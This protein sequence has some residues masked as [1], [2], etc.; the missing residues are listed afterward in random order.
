M[1]FPRQTSFLGLAHTLRQVPPHIRVI[2]FDVFDT[3]IRRRVEPEMVKD[4]VARELVRVSGCGTDWRPLRQLRA[5][6]EQA[7][8]DERLATGRDGEFTLEEMMRRWLAG[9]AGILPTPLLPAVLPHLLAYE[10]KME[11]RA[12]ALTPHIRE[13]LVSLHRNDR[14]IVFVSDMYFPEEAI[15]G[16]LDNLGVG[17]CFAAGYTS[18]DH[19]RRKSTGRLFERVLEREDIAPHEL[20]FV[21]NNAQVDVEP[22]RRL[23]ISAIHIADADEHQRR[24]RLQ[25]IAW[26]G[27]R[28]SLWPG[29]LVREIIETIP[30]RARLD[31]PSPAYQLGLVMALPY[32]AFVLH[33][34]ETLQRLPIRE[35]YF[36]S[37]EG[38]LFFRLYRQL[39]R[40]LDATDLPRGRYLFAG[41]LPTF[42]P[43]MRRLEWAEVLRM[44]RQYNAQSMHVLLTN[45]SL[46]FEHFVPL[47]LRNGITEMEAP[48]VDPE[49]N[50]AFQRFLGDPE[51][52]S[53]FATHRDAAR[54]VLR[55]YLQQIGFFEGGT[56]HIA[57]VDVGWKG[58]I[59]DNLCRA[60][61]ADT[62]FPFVHGIY[63]GL[64][65]AT[66][67]P[68]RSTK[69][70]FLSDGRH[71]DHLSRQVFGSVTPFEM[72]ATAAH[73]SVVGYDQPPHRGG[74]V[75][76]RLRQHGIEVNYRDRVRETVHAI[77]DYLADFTHCLGL[78]EL[79][80]D[81]L[82][83]CVAD[84]LL[85]YVQ[86]PTRLEASV[87]DD[88]A[89]VESFGVLGLS[90]LRW[91]GLA[92][93]L[94]AGRPRQILAEFW[95]MLD[96]HLWP[97]L[98]LR[99]S[100][101]PFAQFAYDLRQTLRRVR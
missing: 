29:R 80:S 17:H 7:L 24:L 98:A 60:L 90:S 67:A 15:R 99:Q 79:R 55:C 70:A 84:Q 14:R 44:W 10:Y 41:R 101:L 20:L 69:T 94:R 59:Q 42:L 47:A 16:F 96:R 13:L 38:W 2:G 52:Q 11:C 62:R 21:G 48:I 25:V 22:A 46:P 66:T 82:R 43:S 73:G 12:Q 27:R 4:A 39:R 3:V 18:C 63:F 28:D 81:L 51:V 61:G 33:V 57:L 8:Y 35:V 86:Y 93:I 95:R 83:P 1:A 19:N 71:P 87:F 76:P 74:R 64:P 6:M 97:G 53:R 23:G 5:S 40:A 37:R 72:T 89:H 45:L 88:Y 75:V 91:D 68:P 58:S 100:R 78:F 77:D 56:G 36:L 34:I 32:I 30:R 85:R 49:D 65:E 92:R 26:A 31:T 54:N 9:A 50:E